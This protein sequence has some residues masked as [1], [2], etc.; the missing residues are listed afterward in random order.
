M[1]ELLAMARLHAVEAATRD[2][3]PYRARAVRGGASRPTAAAPVDS[4][5]CSCT[6]TRVRR[7]QASRDLNPIHRNYYLAEVAELPSGSV[8]NHGMW[9]CAV[10]RQVGQWD[11]RVFEP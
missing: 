4:P 3:S 7:R 9:A 6:L 8:I 5:C 11:H 1:T 2:A 10:A